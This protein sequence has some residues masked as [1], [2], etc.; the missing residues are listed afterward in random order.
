M[1]NTAL[2]IASEAG[3]IAVVKVLVEY[4]ASPLI[5]NKVRRK[6]IMLSLLEGLSVSCR[7]QKN[8]HLLICT[9]HSSLSSSYL[10]SSVHVISLPL[11][12]PFFFLLYTHF[13][14]FNLPKRTAC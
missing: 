10:S 3:Y 5:E 6:E 13:S 2:H 7:M 1:G 9:A 11:N 8:A 14:N 4:G 12:T